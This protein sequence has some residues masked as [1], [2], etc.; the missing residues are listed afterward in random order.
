VKRR[1]TPVDATLMDLEFPTIIPS[2]QPVPLVDFSSS[3]SLETSESKPNSSIINEAKEVFPVYKY[4]YLFS[5]S[6]L[7]IFREWQQK[8]QEELAAK[9]V[10]SE[11]EVEKMKKEAE[12]Y[13]AQE[14]ANRTQINQKRKEANMYCFILP[15][16]SNFINI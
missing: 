13:L 12:E 7:V 16:T 8:H 1:A 3:P 4:I 2:A 10:K 15:F 5:F 6:S 11:Q 14:S 9:K